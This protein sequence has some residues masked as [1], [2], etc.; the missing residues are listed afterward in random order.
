MTIKEC[1]VGAAGAERASQ[2]R[3]LLQFAQKLDIVAP[4]LLN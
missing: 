1:V 4:S 3:N 2:I